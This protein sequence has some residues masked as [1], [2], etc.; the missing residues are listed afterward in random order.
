MTLSRADAALWVN[1]SPPTAV[2]CMAESITYICIFL[3]VYVY[4]IVS[5]ILFYFLM[6][7]SI[8]SLDTS[9]VEDFFFIFFNHLMAASITSLETPSVA[10]LSSHIS[11]SLRQKVG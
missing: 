10:A 2:P 8:T 4:L 6:A 3:Y 9:S 1:D 5:F 7:A 11:F